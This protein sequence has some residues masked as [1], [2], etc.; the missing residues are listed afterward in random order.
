MHQDDLLWKGIIEDMPAYFL[1]FFLQDSYLASTG[2]R[3]VEYVPSL[4]K[5]YIANN[6]AGTVTVINVTTGQTLS[7]VAA[8]GANKLKYIASTNE[9]YVTSTST[10]SIFRI[11][12]S[13]NSLNTTITV[14]ITANGYDILEISSTKVYITV[15]AGTG[16]IMVIDPSVSTNAA[17]VADITTNVPAFP[18]GMAW[19]Q[20]G[21]SSQNG[22]I[23]VA[24]NTGFF[25]VNPS[26]NSVTTTIAN[27]SSAISGGRDCVYSPVLDKY[28]IANNTSNTVVCF[29]IASSTTLAV[30]STIYQAYTIISM[31]IDESN[32][33]LFMCVLTNAS[34]GS[35]AVGV[36]AIRYNET[37]STA[38]S[39]T[40]LVGG[41]SSVAG[42]LSLDVANQRIFVIGYS[43]GLIGQAVSLKYYL[44]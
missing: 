5:L 28:F 22:S 26:T 6:A 16:R 19:N 34:A 35:G 4:D 24:S 43:A 14:S 1:R 2:T 41:G 25:I 40:G 11:G 38:L 23:I 18:A 8:A 20:N 39:L 33:Y 42:A 9:V 27:P 32:G 10:A 30:D 15:I 37:L 17:W 21:S 13:S 3:N 31:G 12:G 29:S 7:T 44:T 36:K